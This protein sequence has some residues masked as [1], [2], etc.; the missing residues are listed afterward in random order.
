MQTAETLTYIGATV[1]VGSLWF[2]VNFVI[3][4]GSSLARDR[5]TRLEGALDLE[6][7]AN[8]LS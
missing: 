2:S 6:R 1:S 4:L 8:D 5:E 7:Q 3:R